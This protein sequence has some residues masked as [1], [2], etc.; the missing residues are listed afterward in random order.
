MVREDITAKD[1]IAILRRRFLL[2]FLLAL[3]GGTAGYITARVLPKRYTSRTL[4]LVQQPSVMAVASPL[5]DN[6]NQRLAAMQ[7]QILSRSRLEPVIQDL[8]LFQKD[9]DRVAME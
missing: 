6:S 4:V 1:A 9:I 5:T 3:F 2:I 7:Q 8:N